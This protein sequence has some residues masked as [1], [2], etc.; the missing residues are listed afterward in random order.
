MSTFEKLAPFIQDY[1]YRN[2]WEELREIQVAACD[3][4]F[5]TDHNLLIAT[6]TASGKTEAAFLPVITE[7]YNKPSKSVGV[8]YIA[9]LKALIN[10]Q[11]SRIEELLEETYIPVTKWHG[12]VSVNM[13]NRLL[14]NPSGILQTTPESLEAMIMKRKEQ[15]VKLFSDLRYMIIDEVHNFIGEERGTQ[16]ISL[17]ERLSKLTG[18]VPRR[19]GLSATLGDIEGT[20]KWLSGGT[21]RLC[22]TPE[23]G[24]KKRKAM[25]MAEHFYEFPLQ[26]E[27]HKND[28]LFFESLYNLT[29][30]KKSIIFS[31]SRA[32]V[33]RNIVNLKDVAVK[34]GELDVFMVHH[35]SIS[36]SDR[37]YVE[38][39]MRMSGMP[40]VAGATVTL[41]LG[42]DLGDLERIVQVGCPK[43]VASLSQ[44][45]GRS[46]RRSGVSEMCFLF[47]E[48]KQSESS[49]FYKLVNWSF[50]KCIALIEL[51][52][53]NRIEPVLPENYP[54]GILYHQTMSYLYGRGEIKP[55]LLAQNLLS[56]YVFSNITKEDYR[57]LLYF[58]LKTGHIEKT[59]AGGLIIGIEGEKIVNHYDFYS[60]FESDVEYSVREGS[61]EIGTLTRL[62]QPDTTFVLGGKTWLVTETDKENK[63]IYVE[64]A[65]GK[66]P[67]VWDGT[68]EVIEH[69]MVLKKMKEIITSETEYP[70]LGEGAKTRL[71]EIRL[72]IKGAGLAE[73]E[74][75][76]ISPDTFGVALW[77]GTR[78]LNSVD[79]ILNKLLSERKFAE[80][81]W[82]FLIVKN[83]TKQELVN[84]IA[85]IRENEVTEADYIIPESAKPMGKYNDFIPDNLLKKQYIDRYTDIVEMKE[86]LRKYP[87]EN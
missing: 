82:P 85:Y 2:S 59:E 83:V 50:V 10:D 23:T 39:Q 3:I 31:N 27:K 81:Y 32:E 78:A 74:I 62:M 36:A 48:E 24:I 14:K 40:L 63:I 49:E 43:S 75:F 28:N 70:Y 79:F 19:I 54:F 55:E 12:D 8:L 34:K 1:I 60:V 33:E 7:L 51:Y 52:R 15:A 16:L 18:I 87:Y 30:G 58:M 76:E 73:K 20:E 57:E 37:E 71:A 77:L 45:L 35:G 67:T 84:A 9:P 46:G 6:P 4:I 56:K 47:D 66:P 44:R 22:V 11:F 25:V 5:N 41:E 65:N 72:I 86:E 13:K 26:D 64:K 80:N 61:H 42:I 69:T 38:E 53:E 21:G 29:R 17:L 68:G